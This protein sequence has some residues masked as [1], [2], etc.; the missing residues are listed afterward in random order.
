MQ[1]ITPFLW[2]VDN[3]EEAMNL[4]TSIF[5]DSKILSVNRMP[6]GTPGPAGK[7]ITGSMILNGQ[8]FMVLNGDP[9][10]NDIF[11]DRISFFVSVDTQEEVD[12]LWD[13]FISSGGKE[14]RCGWLKDTFGLSWQIIPKAL[15]SYLG[16]A[17][18]KKAQAAMQAMLNM[19]KIIIADLEKAV[20]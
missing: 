2:F 20:Q 19:N 3:A 9:L 7:V 5:K 13:K 12:E 17:D 14:G 10:N 16:N 18:P 1:K 4:Y 6:E 8:E 11:N 15:G